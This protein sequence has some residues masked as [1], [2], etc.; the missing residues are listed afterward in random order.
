MQEEYTFLHTGPKHAIWGTENEMP[1]LI[2]VLVWICWEEAFDTNPGVTWSAE[3]VSNI[4]STDEE[5]MEQVLQESSI[6]PWPRESESDLERQKASILRG[7]G[8]H[9]C[10]HDGAG[11][12]ELLEPT[13]ERPRNLV[14]DTL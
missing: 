8:F 7:L 10:I 2:E 1:I 13:D 14:R 6:W 4:T 12:W 11:T 9:E 3:P 5:T